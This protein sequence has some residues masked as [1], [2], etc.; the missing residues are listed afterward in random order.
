MNKRVLAVDD[1]EYILDLVGRI[2]EPEGYKIYTA[3]KV[4]EAFELCKRV[5]PFLLLCDMRLENH[6]DGATLAGM[7]LRHNPYVIRVCITGALEA[8]QKGY[9]IGSPFTDIL[10]KPINVALLR[11]VTRYANDKY[12]RWKS[13]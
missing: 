11:K 6:V 9:L 10:I 8:F 12:E 2:L 5:E 7:I 3:R 13:Y 1:E 4:D